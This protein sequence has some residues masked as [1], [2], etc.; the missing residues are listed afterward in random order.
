MECARLVSRLKKSSGFWYLGSPFT[1]YA[2]GPETAFIEITKI[3]ARLAWMDIKVFAPIIL[4]YP[5]AIH[6]GL[7]PFNHEFWM[8][9]DKPMMDAA[10][11]LIIAMM[12]SW[13]KSQGIK[14]EI[15]EFEA[16]TKPVFYLDPETLEIF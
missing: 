5:M 12:Q 14:F 16:A 11:G 13:E 2:D 4:T 9:F 1:N 3:A 8:D 15:D 10:N 6:G 7:D